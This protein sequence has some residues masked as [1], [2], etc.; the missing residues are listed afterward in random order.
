MTLTTTIRTALLTL[1]LGATATSTGCDQPLEPESTA[2]GHLRVDAEEL[3]AFLGDEDDAE[4]SSPGEN[5]DARPSA[6][7]DLSA[8]DA[9]DATYESPSPEECLSEYCYLNL[10]GSEYSGQCLVTEP[11]QHPFGLDGACVLVP[12]DHANPGC[13]IEADCGP[14]PTAIAGPQRSDA[15]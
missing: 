13:E 3:E 6:E 8:A 10:P 11:G 14:H 12:G 9:D 5:A 15:A 2:D 1:S 4:A 7:F